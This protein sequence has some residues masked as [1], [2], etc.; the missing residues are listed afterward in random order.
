MGIGES[1]DDRFVGGRQRRENPQHERCEFHSDRQLDLR[2]RVPDR[3]VAHQPPQRHEQRRHVRWQDIA[4]FHIR[5]KIAL[6]LAKSDQCAALPR[7]QPRRQ[8][9]PIT[10]TPR[11]AMNRA[12]NGFSFEFPE[13]L[14]VVFEHAL[15]D[16]N[17]GANIEMLHGTA[18]AL[19][20]IGTLR[21]CSHNTRTKHFDEQ[22]L[23]K[24]SFPPIRRVRHAFAG[25]RAFHE[26]HLARLTIVRF[27]ATH[28]L[29]FHI[30]RID[31]DLGGARRTDQARRCATAET[32]GG[33]YD[34]SD[35]SVC[36]RETPAHFLA[37]VKKARL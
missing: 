7:N 1:S 6:P 12:V 32:C 11:R 2:K 3:H 16:G 26:N 17:L 25:Q 30:E 22:R 18:T 21:L 29:R 35:S 37:D 5:D 9:R 15:L 28:A 24:S 13:M 36:D 4:R 20:K 8:P 10:I 14:Q 34:L 23:F 19:A 31:L 33:Y 27:L